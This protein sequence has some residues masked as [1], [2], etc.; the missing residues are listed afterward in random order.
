MWL[1]INV[2]FW[3]VDTGLASKWELEAPVYRCSLLILEALVAMATVAGTKWLITECHACA[4]HFRCII[5]NPH[6]TCIL[7]NPLMLRVAGIRILGLLHCSM[8]TSLCWVRP[9]TPRR[10]VSNRTL[11]YLRANTCISHRTKHTLVYFL[12]E[13]SRIAWGKFLKSPWG[14]VSPFMKQE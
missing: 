9:G 12:G 4:W 7:P 2:Y 10:G 6:F 11:A 1:G 3:G 13:L 8:L 14:S 5:S